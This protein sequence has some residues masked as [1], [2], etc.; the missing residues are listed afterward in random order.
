MT[1]SDV[2]VKLDDR[3]RLM[4]AALA[5]T[6]YPD[7]AQERRP[8]GTH[9]H[10]RTTRRYLANFRAHPAVT[11]LNT[12]LDQRAPLEAL[13]TL[14]MVLRM[15]DCSIERPPRWMPLGW[16]DHLR[17]FF[18]SADLIAFWE[19]ERD[20]WDKAFADSQKAF[21]TVQF[22]PFLSRFIGEIQER[23]YFIPNIS[24]PTDHE[25]CLRL[26]NDLVC[27]V[28]PRLAWGESPPWPY[29]EDPAHVYRASMMQYGR[30]L[31]MNYLRVH[32]DKIGEIAQ[33]P[34]PIGDQ[35]Q[36]MYPTWQEQFANLFVAGAVAIYLQ[37]H[38]SKTEADAYVLMERKV[39][40]ITILPGMISVLRRYLEEKEAGRYASLIDFLPVFP[41]QLK[42]ANR[43]AAL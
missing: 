28:P 1:V 10:A 4:S 16:N 14:A 26:G 18:H 7:L 3:A 23:L 25:M 39:R 36:S 8:H 19:Q 2:S 35:F 29:D 6:R 13:F 38:L 30:A 15:P 34:L 41:R 21:A 32:A 20:E 43:I 9:A 40:G 24:Y 33:T 5:A 27:I 42:V 11:A 12:L 22:K 31:L 37:D 17:D